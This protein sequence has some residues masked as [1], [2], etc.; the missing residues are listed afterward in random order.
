M[1]ESPSIV[2]VPGKDRDTYLVLDDYERVGRAW[3]ETDDDHTSLHAVIID[4]L[5][6]QYRRPV[7]VVGFNTEEG[8]SRD[9][10]EDVAHDLRQRCADQGRELPACLE[11]FVDRHAGLKT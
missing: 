9:V 3:A 6:G 11:Q 5:H 1:R 10:S 7:R 8:W 4:L 2:P